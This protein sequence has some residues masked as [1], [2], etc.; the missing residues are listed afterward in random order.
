MDT[1][2]SKAVLS[3]RESPLMAKVH[4][5]LE[6]VRDE[7]DEHLEAINDNTTEIQQNHELLTDLERRFVMLANKVDTLLELL[8]PESAK[9]ET[10]SVVPLS[11]KEKDV[12]F[13]LYSITE[14]KEATYKDLAENLVCSEQLVASYIANLIEKGVPVVKRYVGKSVYLKLNEAFRQVQAKENLVGL[15]S[16]LSAFGI[17]VV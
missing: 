1:M 8:K 2:R 4:A 10:F 14:D 15:N 5:E 16:K 9:K 11:T 12:F 7:L 17:D 6:G 13:T 3:L